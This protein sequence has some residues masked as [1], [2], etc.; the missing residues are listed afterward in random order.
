MTAITVSSLILGRMDG[1]CE[2]RV[3][4]IVLGDRF[5]VG[6]QGMDERIGVKHLRRGFFQQMR[7]LTKHSVPQRF[8]GV[9]RLPLD[10]LAPSFQFCA[11]PLGFPEGPRSLCGGI[12]RVGI[13]FP[14][15]P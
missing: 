13:V 5:G 12:G 3:L 2:E 15:G 11:L 10:V 9:R 14:D 4:L 8:P 1:G 7:L 6:V